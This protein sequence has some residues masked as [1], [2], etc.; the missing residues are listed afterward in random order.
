MP[1]NELLPAA[2]V[3]MDSNLFVARSEH[4]SV[5]TTSQCIADVFNRRHDNVLRDIHNVING[6]GGMDM[7]KMFVPDTY[8][9]KNNRTCQMYKISFT[10]FI[11]LTGSYNDPA[12]HDIKLRFIAAFENLLQK[13]RNANLQISNMPPRGSKEFIALALID[14]NKIIE[15][16]QKAL[17]AAQPAID[18]TNACQGTTDNILVR[19]YAKIVSQ[20]LQ[21]AGFNVIIGEKKLFKWLIDKGYLLKSGP[22]ADYIPSQNS[23]NLGV[24]FL[25]ESTIG[26]NGKT[27]IRKTSKI[28]PKGQTYFMKKILDIYKNGGTID[29]P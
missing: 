26:V 24:F 21:A 4:N 25:Q 6:G 18:F 1:T 23:I 7:S 15:D 14:A 16:Q 29:T 11:L 3:S 12:A 10:G 20:G 5:Y 28:T 22:N 13:I 17:V 19:N 27:K 8:T 2:D 9:A